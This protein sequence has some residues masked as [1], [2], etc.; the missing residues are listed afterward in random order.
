MPL[1]PTLMAKTNKFITP[2]VPFTVGERCPG[3]Q[4]NPQGFGLVE[5]GQ[6]LQTLVSPTQLQEQ[7]GHLQAGR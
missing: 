3:S 5:G 7:P 2:S 1:K 4:A 6:T